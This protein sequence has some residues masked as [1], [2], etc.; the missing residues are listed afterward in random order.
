[1]TCTDTFITSNVIEN[2]YSHGYYK[3]GFEMY[4]LDWIMRNVAK[5]SLA[6]METS[7][8]KK[9]HMIREVGW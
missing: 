5:M 6:K 4:N 8:F 9:H 3:K 7:M 1:M 2:N